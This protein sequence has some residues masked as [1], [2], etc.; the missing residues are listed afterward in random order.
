MPVLFQYDLPAHCGIDFVVAQD[1][2]LEANAYMTPPGYGPMGMGMGSG[3]DAYNTALG[4]PILMQSGTQGI[5]K[6]Q[7]RYQFDTPV[8]IPRNEIIEGTLYLSEGIARILQNSAGPLLSGYNYWN[9]EGMG[10]HSHYV[11]YGIQMSL[12]GVREV[13][14]R[15][16][17][18][19]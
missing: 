4:G 7:N 17:L 6:K 3:R 18:H 10:R 14:Q 5:P 16:Q 15:G 2:K 19:V 12:M 1:T 9:G 11:R 8:A 13:Q